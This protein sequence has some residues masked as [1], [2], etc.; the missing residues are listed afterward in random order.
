MLN[1]NK[2][3]ENGEVTFRL[4][5]RLD[6]TSAPELEAEVK[7]SLD[8]AKSL[9]MDFEKVEYISSAG[10]RVLL[11]ALK[12]MRSQGQMKVVHV[13]DIVQEVLDVTGFSDMLTIE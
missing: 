12:L 2:T 7:N 11:L 1:I 8:G 10:L 4:E 9:I 5:G 6:T 13:N 3:I